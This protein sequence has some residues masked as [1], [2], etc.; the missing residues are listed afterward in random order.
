MV[1]GANPI[2]FALRDRD[3]LKYIGDEPLRPLPRV[4]NLVVRLSR[5]LPL[6]MV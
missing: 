6:P 2:N 3:A 4:P 1:P 5:M